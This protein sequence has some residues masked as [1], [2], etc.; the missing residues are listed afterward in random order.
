MK[1]N[2]IKEIEY[3]IKDI[4]D[5]ILKLQKEVFNVARLHRALSMFLNIYQSY[6][7]VLNDGYISNIKTY[8]M[9][10]CPKCG[11]YSE[12]KNEKK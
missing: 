9:K 5:K 10:K 8:R 3:D 1:K 12:V 11:E 6:D 2:K 7:G 4:K